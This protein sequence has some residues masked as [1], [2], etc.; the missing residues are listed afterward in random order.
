MFRYTAAW[1]GHSPTPP[2]AEVAFSIECAV[3]ARQLVPGSAADFAFQTN[4]LPPLSS[5]PGFSGSII[6]SMVNVLVGPPIITRFS[7]SSRAE[8]FCGTPTITSPA[9]CPASG[10]S[11]LLVVVVLELSPRDWSVFDDDNHSRRLRCWL[12]CASDRR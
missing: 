1:P 12:R 6:S 2:P 11:K 5:D 10:V 9:F 8:G 7:N 3:Q 4:K